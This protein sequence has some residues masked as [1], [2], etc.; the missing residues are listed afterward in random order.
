VGALLK[1]NAQTVLWDLETFNTRVIGED[2]PVFKVAFSPDGKYLVTAT[3]EE[4]GTVRL[5]DAKM[6]QL[7]STLARVMN[8][9]QLLA[10]LEFSPDSRGLAIA[11]GSHREQYGEVV[12][13]DVPSLK[14]Q[15]RI[16]RAE[17]KVP[18][19]GIAFSPNGRWLALSASDDVHLLDTA[20]TN[21]VARF[22]AY[23]EPGGRNGADLAFSADGRHL[24]A[25]SPWMSAKMWRLPA[26]LV[27]EES[28][29]VSLKRF[30]ASDKPLTDEGIVAEEGGWKITS[31]GQRRVQLFEVRT[32]GIEDALLI[33]RAKLKTSDPE[34]EVSL[35]IKVLH[36]AEQLSTDS[37]TTIARPGT[38]DWSNIAIP[39]RLDEGKR[40]EVVWLGLDIQGSGDVW[41]KD[42][43]LLKERLPARPKD[44]ATDQAKEGLTREHAK[45]LIA[46]A[47][48][49]PND[50]WTKL[51]TDPGGPKAE[52]VTGTP[53]SWLLLTL[54]PNDLPSDAADVRKDFRILTPT[55]PKPTELSRVMWTSIGEGYASIIQPSYVTNVTVS[56]DDVV[57]RGIIEFEAKGLYAGRVEFVAR[58]ASGEWQIEEFYLPNFRVT[59]QLEEDGVW[60]RIEESGE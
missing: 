21:D 20:T 57:A 55:F 6:G 47:A 2:E 48:S 25:V 43:E 1:E 59:I 13:L 8:P 5:W 30:V 34:I 60:R 22:K 19:E 10:N 3:S 35:R 53:L 39:H 16:G 24:F 49:I 58:S 42:I 27:R 28:N 9:G 23:R 40:A 33:Y 52:H 54:N 44:N 46:K 7:V 14:F 32:D 29:T 38:L 56:S 45:S 41:I 26:A 50:E 11:G 4:Q 37:T 51:G 15:R 17:W 36:L 18:I 31:D 12:L